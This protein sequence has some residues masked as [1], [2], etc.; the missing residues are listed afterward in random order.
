M[1]R[2]QMHKVELTDEQRNKLSRIVASS[3]KKMSNE[4][5]VRAKALL[6]LDEAGGKPLSPDDTAKKCKLHRETVY[7]VRKQ[8]ATEGLEASVY[9]KKQNSSRT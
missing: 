5:K 7:N 2:K 6:C 3:P 4:T 8:F 9:R 1:S